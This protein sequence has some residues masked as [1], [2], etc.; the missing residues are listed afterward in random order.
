M[1]G[2][3]HRPVAFA[4]GF[5]GT[6]QGMLE[7]GFVL[8]G[9]ASGVEVGA[10]YRVVLDQCLQSPAYCAQGQVATHQIVTGHLQ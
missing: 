6:L 4:Q 8:D 3:E 1:Q 7:K 5:S 10:V 9:T 2:I